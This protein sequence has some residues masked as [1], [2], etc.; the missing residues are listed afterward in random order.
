MQ[1]SQVNVVATLIADGQPSVA[2]KPGES[3][4]NH[5]SVLAQ[6]LAALYSFTSYAAP[7]PSLAKR[8]SAPAIII[9]FVSVPLVRALARAAS[10]TSWLLD[11][12]NA[13]YHLLKHHTVG[14][15]SARQLHRK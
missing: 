9:R 5:P 10:P 3:A 7:Y 15:V 13:I 8:L 4:L 1:E 12:L 2:V 14:D 6:L 11:R